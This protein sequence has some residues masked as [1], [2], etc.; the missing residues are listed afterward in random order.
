MLKSEVFQYSGSK[1]NLHEEVPIHREPDPGDPEGGRSWCSRC[2]A[3]P[4]ARH[5]RGYVLHLA[6]KVRR[7]GCV[8]D[9]A[10]KGA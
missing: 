7:H 2:G 6:C 3:L 5:E 9:Q 1:E 4:Y 8:D 10:D